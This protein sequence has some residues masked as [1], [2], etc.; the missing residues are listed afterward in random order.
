M[1][2]RTKTKFWLRLWPQKKNNPNGIFEQY[3]VPTDWAQ[4]SL[5]LHDA[6]VPGLFRKEEQPP[7]SPNLNLVGFCVWSYF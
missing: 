6:H 5:A 1:L 4:A 2:S 3:W 7:N